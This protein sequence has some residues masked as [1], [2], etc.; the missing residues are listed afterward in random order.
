MSVYVSWQFNDQDQ[1]HCIHNVAELLVP[2][3]QAGKLFAAGRHSTHSTA[4]LFAILD[5]SKSY[6]MPYHDILPCHVIACMR[7]NSFAAY[8]QTSCLLVTVMVM[9][10]VCLAVCCSPSAIIRP[11]AFR[12]HQSFTCFFVGVAAAVES[13]RSAV[14]LFAAAVVGVFG[15]SS[16]AESAVPKKSQLCCGTNPVGLLTVWM[17]LY[18]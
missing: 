17:G 15:S 13:G 4:N 14:A 3:G 1:K 8:S 6:C 10:R 12:L 11:K 16:T 5:V 18:W 7:Y 9:P 2:Q